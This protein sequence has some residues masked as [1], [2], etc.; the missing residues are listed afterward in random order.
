MND[1][2]ELLTKLRKRL[3][4]RSDKA[5]CD[6][7]EIARSPEALGWEEKARTGAFGF[8]E[9]RAHRRVGTLLG[10]HRAYADARDDVDALIARLEKPALDNP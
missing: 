1:A 5:Y 6:M 4:E 9:L 2:S 3:Q 8:P 7:I 10:K